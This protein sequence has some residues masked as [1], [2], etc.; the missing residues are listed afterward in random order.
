M[1]SERWFWAFPCEHDS[2]RSRHSELGAH[3]VFSR[4]RALLELA[5]VQEQGLSKSGFVALIK[6]DE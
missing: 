1:I 2:L 6:D 5:E 3:R 4:C